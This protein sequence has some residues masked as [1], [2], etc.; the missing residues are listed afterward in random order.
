MISFFKVKFGIYLHFSHHFQP[1]FNKGHNIEVR[2]GDSEMSI[3]H[4]E[5]KV[6]CLLWD[7]KHAA[8]SE[9][10]G[11]MKFFSFKKSSSCRKLSCH[12]AI[13]HW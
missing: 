8:H 10:D 3:I 5:M 6:T 12:A 7:S 1:N 11:T 2:Y 13:G 9:V 4:Y